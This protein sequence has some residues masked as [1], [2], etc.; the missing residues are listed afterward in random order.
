MFVKE[1]VA[2]ERFRCILMY[3]PGFMFPIKTMTFIYFILYIFII[4]DQIEICSYFHV[5]IVTKF[6]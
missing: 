4:G 1:T 5:N 3:L 2:Q 6:L